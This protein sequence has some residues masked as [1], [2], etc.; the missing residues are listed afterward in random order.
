MTCIVG[1]I[2]KKS[3]KTII[4]ADS[5]AV[6]GFE[7]TARKDTKV[8]KSGD[9]II[10]CT[11]SFRMIQL[12]RFAFTPPEVNKKDVYEYMCID[13]I[14]EVRK[15]FESGGY[16]QKDT[17]GDEVGGQFLVG[18]K[19]RLF[20]IDEDFQ[21]GEYLSGMHSVGCGAPYAIGA[22]YSVSDQNISP[23]KKVEIALKAAECYSGGV[24]SPFNF[25]TT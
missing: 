3:K 1:Y 16:L 19:D 15:C 18:Y 4:G 14:N 8:F 5:A 9:F 24:I 7:I 20:M 11:S 10:G 22:L 25:E 13:F 6:D 21:V 17:K 2:D 12:L 23:K